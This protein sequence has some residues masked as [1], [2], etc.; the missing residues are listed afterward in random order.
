MPF[1]EKDYFDFTEFLNLFK[2]RRVYEV[3]FQNFLFIGV[4]SFILA[5][6]ILQSTIIASETLLVMIGA[7]STIVT[8]FFFKFYRERFS[9]PWAL[10]HNLS[11]G[12][13]VVAV[14]LYSN[15][16]FSSDESHEIVA[17]ERAEMRSASKSKLIPVVEVMVHGHPHEIEF[18]KVWSEQI[19]TT[20]SIHIGVKQ[21]L[22]GYWIL[23]SAD[24]LQRNL[25]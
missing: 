6:N 2:V 11:I 8:A 14:F 9:L 16:R 21:G 4:G 17:I 3:V 7:T 25:Q 22:W 10:I 15:Y 12:L 20:D 24:M 19:M 1:T 13:F 5:F 18:P 23:T